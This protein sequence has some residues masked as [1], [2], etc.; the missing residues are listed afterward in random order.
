MIRAGARVYVTKT[1][2]GRLAAATDRVASCD[3]VS[4]P[5]PA[6]FV[7]TF[8]RGR[9]GRRRRQLDELTPR[10]G[11][12]ADRRGYMYKEIARLTCREDGRAVRASGAQLST[13]HGADMGDR[14]P[15]GLGDVS[16]LGCQTLGVSVT[17]VRSAG[18]RRGCW[19]GTP[20]VAGVDHCL[21]LCDGEPT[22]PRPTPA[23]PSATAGWSA[24]GPAPRPAP[25]RA[26]GDRPSRSIRR[27]S[28]GR[29]RRQSRAGA[30]EAV[31]EGVCRALGRRL[32]DP[33]A[34]RSRRRGDVP[35][36]DPCDGDQV[37]R[38]P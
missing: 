38:R 28:R 22:A 12:P 15:P 1:I 23:R 17:A 7:A 29:P 37:G 35:G 4:S 30:G 19:T 2:S 26:Y 20:L 25:A 3:P 31:A 33:C 14:A 5:P 16:H 6:G 11:A 9:A 13:R 8:A 10:R 36:G 18:Q 24:S 21:E 34:T 32:G 27:C